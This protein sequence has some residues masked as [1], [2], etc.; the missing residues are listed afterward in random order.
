MADSNKKSLSYKLQKNP[1]LVV[2]GI[3]AIALALFI[4]VKVS[5]VI[6]EHNDNKQETEIITTTN[7]ESTDSETEAVE[8][9]KNVII[10]NKDIESYTVEKTEDAVSLVVKFSSKKRLLTAHNTADANNSDYIPLFCFY[11]ADGTLFKCPGE[12]KLDTK[13]ETATYTLSQFNDFAIAFALTDDKTVTVD[14]IL[15]IPFNI[16]VQS[17]S[18]GEMGAT[19]LGTYVNENGTLYA[20]HSVDLV[21]PVK[22]I[23]KVELTKNDE[24]M[25]LD[26]YYDDFAA[27]S[28]LNND[29]INSNVSF[30]LDYNGTTYKRDF[31]TTEYDSLNMVRC[32]YD[33]YAMPELC[34]SIGN[35]SLTVN[36]IFSQYNVTVQSATSDVEQTLFSMNGVV[37]IPTED[38]Q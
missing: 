5:S 2:L 37:A 20:N 30:I 12:L 26:I 8:Q 14:N 23:K 7:V 11:G 24:F 36:D 13:K 17:K 10:Y 15:D 16:C 33:S 27:Y 19:L 25:W 31:I 21:N 18:T 3:V 35:S 34:D 22:G 28:K 29:F 32:K 38:V 4:V 6:K 1:L 9:L